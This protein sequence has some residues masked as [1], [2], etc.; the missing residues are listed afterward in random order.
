MTLKCSFSVSSLSLSPQYTFPFIKTPMF[1]LNSLYDTWQIPNILQVACDFPD[2]CPIE[3]KL[4]VLG[5]RQVRM[6]NM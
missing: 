6:P 2:G 3:Q 1:Q 5:Y 4:A